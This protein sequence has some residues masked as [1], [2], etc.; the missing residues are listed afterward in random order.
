[1]SS[2]A[3]LQL[4]DSAFPSGGF[5]HSGG[6]EAAV[7]AGAVRSARELESLVHGVIWQCAI[8]A[9]PL[10]HAAHDDSARLEE[11]DALSDATLWS[12]VGKRASRTQGRAFL[13]AASKTWSAPSIATWRVALTERRIEGH[14]APLFGAVARAVEV[15][16]EETSQAFLHA[17][18]RS[19][20]SAGVRLGVL[21]PYEAQAMTARAASTLERA[22]REGCA[23]S[24]DELAQ[25]MPIL[26]L[27]QG[28]QDLLY[29]RLFQS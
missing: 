23:R 24:V 16:R 19:I 11:L 3:L 18:L 7:Q 9:L 6:L 21:G 8:S 4:A 5:A 13:D 17:A 14:F 22:L 28:T 15:S 2:W 29:S 26:E 20:L 12:H 10:V 1:M 27:L 25:P